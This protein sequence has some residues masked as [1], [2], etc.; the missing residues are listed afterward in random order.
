AA[1][2]RIAGEETLEITGCA[3]EVAE[4]EPG[5]VVEDMVQPGDQQQAVKYAIEEQP[6]WS[7]THHPATER[8]DASLEPGKT[9]AKQGGTGDASQTGGHRNDTAA[10]QERQTS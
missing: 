9:D 1:R 8:V 3:V 6:Q 10:R 7:G 2:S 4:Q 5:D